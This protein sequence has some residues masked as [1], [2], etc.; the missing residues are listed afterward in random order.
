M[1]TR[2]DRANKA[3]L[4]LDEQGNDTE[5]SISFKFLD[6]YKENNHEDEPLTDFSFEIYYQKGVRE[7]NYRTGRFYKLINSSGSRSARLNL[8][9]SVAHPRTSAI[10]SVRLSTHCDVVFDDLTCMDTTIPCW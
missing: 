10:N 6:S 5:D 2:Y 4:I 3:F 1:E 8:S 9:E 7:S